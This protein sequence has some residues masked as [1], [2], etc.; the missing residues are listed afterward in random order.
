MSFFKNICKT[1]LALSLCLVSTSHAFSVGGNK[2][3]VI[4][5]SERKVYSI[6]TVVPSKKWGIKRLSDENPAYLIKLLRDK[7]TLVLKN[8][9]GGN[10]VFRLENHGERWDIL[11][12]R[13]G[14]EDLVWCKIKKVKKDGTLLFTDYSRGRS[15][16]L[17]YEFTPEIKKQRLFIDVSENEKKCIYELH[18][19]KLGVPEDVLKLAIYA[20]LRL[21]FNLS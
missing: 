5:L 20:I 16:K 10:Y 14:S 7:K 6:E 12:A 18:R 11:D 21:T 19:I 2:V 15:Y 8:I 17:K 1:L 9:P 13:R 4:D 3:D